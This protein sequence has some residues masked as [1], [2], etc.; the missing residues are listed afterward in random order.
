[1]ESMHG[2][3]VWKVSVAMESELNC[4][5]SIVW[6]ANSIARTQL[7]ELNCTNSIARTQLHELNCTNSI[8]RTQL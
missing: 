8:A 1:M 7:H 6:K 4:A 3:Y 2:E 5:N